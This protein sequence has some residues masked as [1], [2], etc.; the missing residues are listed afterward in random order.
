[1]AQDGAST[2]CRYF[3]VYAGWASDWVTDEKVRG[4]HAIGLCKTKDKIQKTNDKRHKTKEKDKRQI[5]NIKDKDKNNDKDKA[6][7]K[8]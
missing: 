2:Q 3:G 4:L 8:I 6:K 7:S 1:M 5:H